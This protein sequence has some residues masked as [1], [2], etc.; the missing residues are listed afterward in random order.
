MQTNGKL[1]KDWNIIGLGADEPFP[2]LKE[3]LSLFGQFIGDWNIIEARYPQPDG[4]E[5]KRTGEVHFGWI[6]EGKAIQD[7]W[8]SHDLV[9]GKPKPRGTTIRFYDPKIDA[10]H[11][12]WINPD[13]CIIQILLARKI[14]ENIVLEGKTPEGYPEKWI[15]SEIKP[16]SFKWHSVESHD[17]GKTWMLT[18]EMDL[19]RRH[20][21]R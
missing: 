1:K 19:K 8:V 11:I 21:K 14:E 16:N 17:D 3:K 15:F 9:T 5:I 6:L 20:A 7:V 12:I 10:W 13:R 2:E 18:E 4:T